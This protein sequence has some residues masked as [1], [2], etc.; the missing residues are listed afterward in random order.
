MDAIL[1]TELARM[2]LL[3]RC[4]GCAFFRHAGST[5]PY[6]SLS[7][8]WGWFKVIETFSE[9]TAVLEAIGTTIEDKSNDVRTFVQPDIAFR[10]GYCW[11]YC[12]VRCV[13]IIAGY[14]NPI[15]RWRRPCWIE[16][17]SWNIGSSRSSHR[18]Y[19]RATSFNAWAIGLCAAT[20]ARSKHSSAN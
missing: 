7:R 17:S 10:R 1:F 14:S 6:L 3:K 19:S 8:Q 12:Q 5:L 16:P 18:K 20:H 13:A 4:P 15:F 2:M 11:K 9:T